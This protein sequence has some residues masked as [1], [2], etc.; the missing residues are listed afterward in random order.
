MFKTKELKNKTIAQKYKIPY[1]AIMAHR[2]LSFYAPEE[3]LPAYLLALEIGEDLYLEADIQ[4]TKDGVL[5][6]FHDDDLKSTTNIQKYF[7]IKSM[8][9]LAI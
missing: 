7:Q 1:P 5:V 3:T 2:G 6:C 8:L 4:R 9:V